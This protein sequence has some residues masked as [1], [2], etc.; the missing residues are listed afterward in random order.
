MAKSKIKELENIDDATLNL[1]AEAF[2]E[3]VEQEVVEQT[4]HDRYQSYIDQAKSGYIIGFTYPMAM[5][6]LRYC[7]NKRGI[8]FGLN[9]SC[10][11]CMID[12]LLM[13][14]RLR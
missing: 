4:I 13:F 11:Q 6:V 9:M 12:L 5:E 8:Q 3:A 7:E 14:D 2:V 1:V 10:G